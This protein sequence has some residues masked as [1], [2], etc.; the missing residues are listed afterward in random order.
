MG[1]DQFDQAS[2]GIRRAVQRYADH[3]DRNTLAMELWRGIPALAESA[4]DWEKA[5]RVA[6]LIAGRWQRISNEADIWPSVLEGRPPRR[7]MPFDVERVTRAATRWLDRLA[8]GLSPE[9]QPDPTPWP[10]PE[11]LVLEYGVS[12][13][14][15]YRMLA[16]RNDPDRMLAMVGRAI[17]RRSVAE[18]V[19]RGRTRAAARR[20]LDR[21]PNLVG[22]TSEASAP[23]SARSAGSRTG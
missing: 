12:R 15:A 10:N 6:Q 18:L 5:W 4:T 23:R 1:A 20:L 14:T 2:Q 17:R 21:H 22:D 13:A 9:A 3:R 7:D 16:A 8:R 19:A 11:E